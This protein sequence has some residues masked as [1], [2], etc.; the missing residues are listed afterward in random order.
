MPGIERIVV[1]DVDEVASA[2]AAATAKILRERAADGSAP[3]IALTGG[4]AG[5]RTAARLAA[6]SVPWEKLDV[7]LGD[8][9]FLAAGDPDRNDTQL[10][11]ALFDH[12]VEAPRIHRW[13]EFVAGALDDVDAAAA[14]FADQ[15]PSAEPEFDVH[16]LGMGGEGHVNSVFPDS[17]AVAEQARSVVGVRNCPKP[18]A[19]R[20]TF[21]LPAIR[22]ARHVFVVVAGADKA[23]AVARVVAGGESEPE[24]ALPAAGAIGRESTV[25]FLDRAAASLL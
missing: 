16:L 25:F 21:T 9:R 13:P 15:V 8:E 2:A 18:P 1:A 17:P 19:E 11:T 23:E 3:I 4:T 22:R 5:V 12:L 20:M 24:T 7:Y 14:R 6:E 10:A